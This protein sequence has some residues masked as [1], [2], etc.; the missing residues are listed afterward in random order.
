[1]LIFVELAGLPELIE[2][3]QGESEFVHVGAN[4]EGDFV[5]RE[6]HCLSVAGR[7]DRQAIA[8]SARATLGAWRRMRKY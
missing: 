3:L 4:F 5:L 8:S 6:I 2:T 1:M 7:C